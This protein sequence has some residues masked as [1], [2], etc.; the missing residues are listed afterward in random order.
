MSG[1]KPPIIN[2][3]IQLLCDHGPLMVSDMVKPIGFPAKSIHNKCLDLK[4]MGLV[5]QREKVWYLTPGVTPETLETGEILPL[6]DTEE[7]GQLEVGEGQVGEEGPAPAGAAPTRV[8]PPKGIALDQKGQFIQRLQSLGVTPRE[9]IP[10]IADIFFSGDINNLSWLDH[11]LTKEAPGF[12]N[13][14]QRKLMH[15]FWAH[16]RGLP[17][18]EDDPLLEEEPPR[19]GGK[20]AKK[21]ADPILN[22]P[23]LGFKVDKDQTGDWKPI[24][25]G[26]LT[27]EQALAAAERRAVIDSYQQ[28]GQPAPEEEPEERPDRAGTRRGARG[29]ESVQD[30]ILR[31]LVDGFFDKDKGGEGQSSEVAVLRDEI[32]RMRDQQ[33]E[34][35]FAN[36]EANIASIAQ[37]DPWDDYDRAKRQAERFGW[38]PPSGVTDQSP[39]VQLIKDS[40][41]KI[42][43]GISRLVGI[44]ERLALRTGEFT[45]EETRTPEE[46]ENQAGALL[47]QAQGRERSRNLRMKAFGV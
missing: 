13:P 43:K 23:G 27:Y 47:D 26:P 44:L 11:V 21:A 40:G 38:G 8:M 17:Y 15:A 25:G 28:Q 37:R 2:Q 35:R 29:R 30:M 34:D 18:D 45:P 1:K 46:R 39:A 10:T 4:G 19:S 31:K 7:E 32:A 3:V 5:E 12:V 20:A 24:P 22:V 9:A 36:M 33:Q 41:D 6:V 42:D 14:Q 16:T